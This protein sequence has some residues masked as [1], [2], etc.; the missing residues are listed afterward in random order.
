M[1]IFYH[2]TDTAEKAQSILQTGFL[3]GTCFAVNLQDALTFGGKHIFHVA[4]ESPPNDWQF[5]SAP[6]GPEMI[7]KYTIHES[8]VVFENE[9]L[10][11]RIFESNLN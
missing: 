10:R 4:F 2:G 6:I 3:D 1:R 8:K 11:Q 7:V 9:V 5:T